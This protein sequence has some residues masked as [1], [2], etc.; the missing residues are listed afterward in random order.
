MRPVK[1]P[2]KLTVVSAING[3]LFLGARLAGG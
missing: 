3:A 2:K 1:K